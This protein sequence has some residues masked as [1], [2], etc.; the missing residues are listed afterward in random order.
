M[1]DI[2]LHEYRPDLDGIRA[3]A[4]LSVVGFHAFPELL[5]GGFV[6]VDIF[7]VISGFLIS[8]IIFE[9]LANNSFKLIDFYSRR[10]CRIFPALIVVLIACYLCGWNILLANEFGLLGKHIAGGSGFVSNL[11]FW[12]EVGYFDNPA[13]TK[14][15]LHLW[16]L[17]IEEQFYIFWPITIVVL[18]RLGKN[19]QLSLILIL[20][21][22][23]IINIYGVDVY[24]VATFYLPAPRF[25]EF[26]CGAYLNIYV[27]NKQKSPQITNSIQSNIFSL[28]GITILGL[29][30]ALVSKSSKF[31]GWPALSPV[32]GT[33]LLIL[34]GPTAWINRKLLSNKIV[35][36]FGS[37]SYPL[38][39]WHW[40]LLSFLAI[41][42]Y[43]HL[44]Y[45]IRAL[46]VAFAILLAWL[47][48]RF[49][50]KPIRNRKAI[51][52]KAFFL[53]VILFIIGAVGFWTL[54]KS[55]FPA[56]FPSQVNELFQLKERTEEHYRPHSCFLYPEESFKTFE[57]C[58]DSK[59]VK[60]PILFLWGDSY[61]ADLY[62]GYRET[63][64]SRYNII[65]R[66]AAGC[67]PIVDID[68][69]LIPNCRDVNLFVFSEILRIRPDK[70]VL[71]ARWVLHDW[72]KIDITINKLKMNGIE[73]IDLVGPK[74][75]WVDFLPTELYRYSKENPEKE[76]PHRMSYH[77][78][79]EFDVLDS[80]MQEHFKKP[81]GIRYISPKSIM[82][83]D[84]G[85]ITRFGNN[86]ETMVTWDNGHL[87]PM[88][89]QYLVSHFPKE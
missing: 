48:S 46:A 70:V 5:G 89:S 15:L 62:E 7:F 21:S 63:F 16:S 36:W 18:T 87:R 31:P 10:I 65:Q 14:P 57:K 40:P 88:A 42:Y 28:I 67:P 8:K 50:E 53:F 81:F 38:Y 25:W 82:C 30:I 11:I 43:E 71:S 77:L 22:S 27:S 56:R 17:G 61:A 68:L 35:V 1:K 33:G 80:Q 49:I 9:N 13:Q 60:R 74:P 58:K 55:G 52:L 78:T 34:A 29:A 24:P 3:I 79:K 64:G 54:K 76:I 59:S 45:N 12:R 86:A 66:T 72:K 85:C 6:G 39:L 2:A 4:V 83:N 26:L 75:E 47:T 73:N 44:S 19:I 84:A 69:K 23:F 32:F 37:I 51:K 41:I 20:L